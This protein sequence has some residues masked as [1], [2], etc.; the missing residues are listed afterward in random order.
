M[1]T[2][3]K[4]FTIVLLMMLGFAIN[5]FAQVPVASFSWTPTTPC[6]GQTVQLTST[7]TNTGAVT[8]YVYSLTGAT[9]ATVLGQNAVATFTASGSQTVIL[10]LANG[11]TPI[12][13]ATN[14]ITVLPSPT[15]GIT[16]SSAVICP[17]S[18]VVL[19]ATSAP[20][21][22]TYSWTAPATGTLATTTVS[23]QVNTTFSC[24]VTSTANGCTKT[25]TFSQVVFQPTLNVAVTRTTGICAGESNTFVASGANSN[26]TWNPG[27]IANATAVV[28]PTT[29][30]TYSL[31]FTPNACPNV[32]YTAT[33]SQNVS[34]CTGIP[35]VANTNVSFGV[36][37]NPTTGEFTIELNNGAAKTISIMDLTGRVILTNNSAEDKINMNLTS[38][39]KGIY[40]VR[41]QSNNTIEVAKIVIQ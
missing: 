34:P 1:K 35:Q 9:Q 16:T 30:T 18:T 12:G 11:M 20:A 15:V 7:S 40:Y 2:S 23:M 5:S 29:T 10:V 26:Y 19:T 17:F 21:G 38:L 4:S 36:Y 6:P 8:A 41:V 32:V 13:S 14:I 27:A 33:L 37:P 28:S 39:A 31:N 24:V 3:T 25:G 22:C